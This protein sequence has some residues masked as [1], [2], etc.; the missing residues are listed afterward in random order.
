MVRQLRKAATGTRAPDHGD[1]HIVPVA[2]DKANLPRP[3]SS[4]S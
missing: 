2:G 1:S 3:E 4:N